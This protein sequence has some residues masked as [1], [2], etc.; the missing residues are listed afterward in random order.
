MDAY[1]KFQI[2]FFLNTFAPNSKFLTPSLLRKDLKKKK[3]IKQ[4]N[5]EI[6]IVHTK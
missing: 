1:L 3:K 4:T 5:K 6:H 2:F